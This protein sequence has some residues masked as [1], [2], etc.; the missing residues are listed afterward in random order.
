MSKNKKDAAPKSWVDFAVENFKEIG[1]K[2]F[3]DVNVFLNGTW[4]SLNVPTFD[5]EM[6]FLGFPKGIIEI[7]GESMSGKTSLAYQVLA[8]AVEVHGEN[9]SSM[10]FSAENRDNRQL[11][12]GMRMDVSKVPVSY[13]KNTE[14]LQNSIIKM[15]EEGSKW[16]KESGREGKQKFVFVLDSMSQLFSSSEAKKIADNADKNDDKA[17]N[18]GASAKANNSMLRA[19]KVLSQDHDLT[20]LVINRT[21]DKIGFMQRGKV[22]AGGTGITYL[23]NVR[24]E[25]RRVTDI[26]GSGSD[27]RAIGQEVEVTI[28]KNDF[29]AP[30]HKFIID[31]MFGYGYT[32]SSSCIKFGLERGL[33]EKYSYGFKSTIPGIDVGWKNKGELIDL[34][35]S[36][37]QAF[38]DLTTRITEEAH[39][40]VMEKRGLA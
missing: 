23:P 6:E 24:I 26:K 33:L 18:P 37:D 32:L 5:L 8:N 2:P 9:C 20:L 7:R 29:G 35:R 30:R 22:S 10:I 36:G 25:L 31:L 11:A 12:D 16:W 13:P 14:E 3:S 28:I 39:T 38:W 17:Q 15:V 34:L 27:T 40:V 1:T 4:A 21:Y 19:V